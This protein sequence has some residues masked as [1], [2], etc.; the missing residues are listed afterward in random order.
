TPGKVAEHSIPGAWAIFFVVPPLNDS[1]SS[2]QSR[3]KSRWNKKAPG[4][5]RP[6]RDGFQNWSMCDHCIIVLSL[7]QSWKSLSNS[8]FCNTIIWCMVHGSHHYAWSHVPNHHRTEKQ[9][10]KRHRRLTKTAQAVGTI[11]HIFDKARCRPKYIEAVP[12]EECEE[13]RHRF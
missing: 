13:L 10:L 9:I 8:S 4:S 6:E 11:T 1:L 2:P 12:P 3:F 5:R 7:Q